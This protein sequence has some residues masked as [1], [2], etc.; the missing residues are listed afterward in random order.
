MNW[1]K[2]VGS[3]EDPVAEDWAHDDAQN[4]TEI[5]FPWN[6]PPDLWSP[7]RIILYAVGS[8]ALI[9]TQTSRRSTQHQAPPG[10]S[11]VS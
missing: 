4:F 2:L 6:K 8:R 3:T 10:A 5:R 11:G 1:F 9:A 7:G